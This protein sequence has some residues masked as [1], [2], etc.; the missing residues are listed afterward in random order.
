MQPATPNGLEESDI[1]SAGVTE[2]RIAVSP[3]LR[4]FVQ[5]FSFVEAVGARR[6]FLPDA[7]ARILVVIEPGALQAYV[8]G[9]RA[10]TIRKEAVRQKAVMVRLWPG[11][12]PALM[13]IPT[14]D[15]ASTIVPLEALWGDSAK[16]LVERL[17]DSP[18]RASQAA[19]VERA[20]AAHARSLAGARIVRGALAAFDDLEEARVS[21][22]ALRVGVSERHLRRLFHDSVGLSPRAYLRVRRLRRALARKSALHSWALVAAEAGYSDQAHMVSEFRYLTGRSPIALW[23]E[24]GEST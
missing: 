9:P 14:V 15:V 21:T 10:T 2:E 24:L 5:S 3:Q 20:I 19:I 12:V 23:R 18:D 11:A 8:V 7:F 6:V 22:V 4:R 16:E 1:T 13:A 17:A